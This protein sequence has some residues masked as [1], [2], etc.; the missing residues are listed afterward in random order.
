M[1][2]LNPFLVEG[3]FVF[4]SVDKHELKDLDGI[5][6]LVFHESEGTTII[7]EKSIADQHEISYDSTW[8]LITLKVQSSLTTVGLLKTITQKLGDN[9]IP[10]NVVSAV[11]HDHLFVPFEKAALALKL[12]KELQ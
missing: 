10:V 5:P 6:L 11:Y 9:N 1:K 7:I 8:A 2:N 4:A 3:E 12:L